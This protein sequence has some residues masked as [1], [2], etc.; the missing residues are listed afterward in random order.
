[1]FAGFTVLYVALSAA[2]VWGVRRV[3]TG[4]P[5]LSPGIGVA[6]R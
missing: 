6:W 5:E 4:R 1:M 2:T 3:S